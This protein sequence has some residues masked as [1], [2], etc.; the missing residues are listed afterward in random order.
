VT[1][2]GNTSRPS[3]AGSVLLTYG[4]SVLASFLS[5][6]SVIF[7]SRALGPEGRGTLAF[8]TT[9]AMLTSQLSSLG[10]EE[11]SANVVGREPQRR[12]AL[13]T[14]AILLALGLGTAGLGVVALLIAIFPG[15]AGDASSGLLWLALA[16]VPL[17]VLQF[18]LQFIIRADYG[19]VATNVALLAAPSL[20]VLVN[21]LLFLFDALTVRAAMLTWI[22]GQV[23]AT[24]LLLA[25]VSR[26]LAGFGKPDA[27]LAAQSLGFGLK[28]HAG[29]VMKTG[30]YRLDQWLL[31]SLAGSRE[32][33]L[34]SV[35]VAWAEALFFLPEALASVLRPDLVR[36]E[37]EYAGARGAAV[38]RIAVVLTL[39][40]AICFIIAAPLLCVWTFGEEFRGS[41]DD[42]RV[43]APGA[44]G[45]VALKLL[46]NALVAQRRPGLSNVAIGLAFA[47]TVGLDLLLIPQYGGLGAAIA[48]TVAYTA[49][50]AA[51]A[52][53]FARALNVS[54]RRMF[55]AVA[56]LR[57]LS[58]GL[59]RLAARSG[60]R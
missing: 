52:V 26:R 30:N 51:V 37:T 54:L 7:T 2:A 45:I 17:L 49:G 35:A 57:V 48:S 31:G 36:A 15:I 16:S 43:L 39:V 19:F 23:L 22:A 11:A 13:G 27:K 42:L 24:A 59:A 25:Y 3:F 21:G 53:I 38:F 4:A 56:D 40:F 44:L 20:N 9:V 32:L 14:N 60:S 33:G 34:Y 18:Y 55:P 46:G 50:G 1:I 5:L 10:V 41:I 28:T 8:L 58:S 47:V 12:S 6:V 29:R